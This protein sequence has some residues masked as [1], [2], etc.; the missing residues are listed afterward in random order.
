M[1]TRKLTQRLAS[2]AALA[3]AV[4]WERRMRIDPR[5][6]EREL[7]R[8]LR[9]GKPL[10]VGPWL[11]EIGF[12]VLYW[13]PMLT[14]LWREH[15]IDPS[16]VTVISRGGAAPWYANLA[17]SYVDVLDHFT[18][19][20]VAEWQRSRHGEEGGQKHF[21]L[22]SFDVEVLRRA[23]AALPPDHCLVH[24]GTMYRRFLPYW[25][26]RRGWWSVHRSVQYTR[27]PTPPRVT[28]DLPEDYV[29]VK[30]YFSDCFPDTPENRAF[31]ATLLEQL[32]ARQPVVLLSAGV[33]L[34]DHADA[35]ERSADER[36]ISITDSMQPNDNL[37]IQT[38][39]IASARALVCT[40]GGFSYLGPFLDVP[41][42]SFYS[43]A[44]FNP[45][46]LEAAH[47]AGRK[48]GRTLVSFSVDDHTTLVRTLAVNEEVT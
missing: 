17:H 29:A 39:V 13:I 1:N 7:T 32:C 48:L 14:R 21:G 2:P 40:Y 27:L 25:A 38:A 46:H 37:A 3:A 4:R 47:R 28:L 44:N 34:D 35:L 20:E 31:L 8:A 45:T 10:V 15:K 42:Y 12:E 43:K 30:A 23:G 41:T 5:A 9:S 26:S 33:Q 19:D 6:A 36:I 24:P 16:R 18:P 11:S 22:T